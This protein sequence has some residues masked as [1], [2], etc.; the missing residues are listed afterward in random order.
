MST[1][2]GSRE[3]RKNKPTKGLRCK[4]RTHLRSLG[5]IGKFR[6]DELKN[7]TL[8]VKGLLEIPINEFEGRKV[9]LYKL[10]GV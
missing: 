9:I 6:T 10:N 8:I 2:F 4:L 5:V 7:G 1:D 3:D